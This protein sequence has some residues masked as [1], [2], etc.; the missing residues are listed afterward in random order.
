MHNI[1][2]LIR[3]R[4]REDRGGGRRLFKGGGM[5]EKG[6]DV[7]LEEKKWFLL[8]GEGRKCRLAVLG[9]VSCSWKSGHRGQRGHPLGLGLVPDLAGR[10][11]LPQ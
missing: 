4:L 2:S 11:R 6:G 8:K 3:I 9:G 10:I 7:F 1:S 5:E